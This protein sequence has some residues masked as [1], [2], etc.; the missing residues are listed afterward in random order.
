MNRVL[1]TVCLCMLLL[2][3]MTNKNITGEYTTN[4]ATYGMFGKTLKLN[5][6]S[7]AIL[8]FAGDLMNDNSSGKWIIRD[9]ILEVSLDTS[10]KQ[11]Y[12]GLYKFRIRNKRLFDFH[13]TKRQYDSLKFKIDSLSKEENQK[14]DIPSYAKLKRGYSGEMKNFSGKTGRQFYKKTK[15]YVCN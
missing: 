9:N 15:S 11:R 5:C 2:S 14:V 8:N 10:F 12:S 6:D 3:C 7:T 1:L 4:F 13:L